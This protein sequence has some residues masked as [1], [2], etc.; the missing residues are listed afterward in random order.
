MAV[1]VAMK[2][3]TVMVLTGLADSRA[4]SIGAFGQNMHRRS[5]NEAAP[6]AAARA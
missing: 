5:A 4:A 2:I 3:Q 6:I 1:M